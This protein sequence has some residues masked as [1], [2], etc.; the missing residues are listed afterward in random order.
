MRSMRLALLTLCLTP[1]LADA[2][3]VASAEVAVSVFRSVANAK[4]ETILRV[5]YRADKA[6][7]MGDALVVYAE[8]AHIPILAHVN[9]K[10]V[11]AKRAELALLAAGVPA[12]ASGSSTEF[13][14]AVVI[15]WALLIARELREVAVVMWDGPKETVLSRVRVDGLPFEATSTFSLG[16]SDSGALDYKLAGQWHHCCRG[17]LCGEICTDCQSA[18]FSCNLVNCEI[19]CED[20]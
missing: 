11:H 2:Q 17:P 8:P 1:A 6:A 4:P 10:S 19:S 15:P 7:A 16:L 5:S 18:F 20:F 9:G 13:S 12:I 3:T 14:Q